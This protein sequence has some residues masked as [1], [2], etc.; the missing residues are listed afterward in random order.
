MAI[1]QNSTQDAFLNQLRK[2]REQ[3]QITT[4][5]GFKIKCRIR[6][7]DRFSLHVESGDWEQIIFKHAI[8]TISVK[9]GFSNKLKIGA[10]PAKEPDKVDKVEKVEKVEKAEKGEEK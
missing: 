7:F 5:N 3:V 6:G 1:E 10:T 8:A 4:T 2:E 9:R